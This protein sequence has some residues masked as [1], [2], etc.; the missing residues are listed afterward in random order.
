MQFGGSPENK[1]IDAIEKADYQKVEKLISK[2]FDVNFRSD[3]GGTP[4]IKSLFCP[5][6]KI[7]LLLF[8]NGADINF[9][10]QNGYSPL[11]ISCIQNNYSVT[12]FLIEKGANIHQKTLEGWSA[13]LFSS[14]NFPFTYDIITSDKN[15]ELIQVLHKQ[16]NYH[17]EHDPFE[18][19]DLLIKKGANP[20]D[21]NIHG[22]TP[23]MRASDVE[24]F[25]TIELLLQSGSTINQRDKEGLNALMHAVGSSVQTYYNSLTDLPLM[26]LELTFYLGFP[27]AV[28]RDLQ[29]IFF[30]N[31]NQTAS[32]LI[33]NGCNL[34]TVDHNGWTALMHATRSG[35]LTLVKYLK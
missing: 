24:N 6:K 23:L 14:G 25:K 11:I 8:Q 5:N 28:K 34:N 16:T 9:T 4:L 30:Q 31:Q 29:E 17:P 27:E 20:N 7:F 1:L 2:K 26:N 15:R 12:N 35:N 32:L 21:A 19:V 18:S 10:T 3:K 13:L 33:E 22:I